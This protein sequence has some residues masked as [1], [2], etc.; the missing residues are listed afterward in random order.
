MTAVV[1]PTSK[2]VAKI[3]AGSFLK[4][5]P[6]ILTACDGVLMG[7]VVISNATGEHF[8]AKLQP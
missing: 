5:E 4:S 2:E 6:E 1:N 7:L 3:F 8:I